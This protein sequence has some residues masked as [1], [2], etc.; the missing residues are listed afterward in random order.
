MLSA[1]LSHGG[2]LYSEYMDELPR[3]KGGIPK[4][5]LNNQR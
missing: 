2:E 5:Y 4:A 1:R 3:V